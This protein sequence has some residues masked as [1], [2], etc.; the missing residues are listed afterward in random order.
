MTPIQLR[1][2]AKSKEILE[3][4]AKRIYSYMDLVNLYDETSLQL[5]KPSTYRQTYTQN[6]FVNILLE[7]KIIRP[8]TLHSPYQNIPVRYAHG[9]FS[10]YELA[11]SIQKGAYLSHGTAA[12]FHGLTSEESRK[13]YVNKEQS[14]K[15][16]GKGY[17]TQEALN[18]AF[19]R[20]QR[21]SKYIL[22]YGRSRITL[23]NGKNTNRLGVQQSHDQQSVSIDLT[24][25][26]RTLIDITVRPAYAG[27]VSQVL[28]CFVAARNRI[29]MMETIRILKAL[30]YVYPYHQ[31]LGF[32]LERAGFQKQHWSRLKTQGLPYDFYLM[33]GEKELK[34]DPNW[35]IFYP[36]ELAK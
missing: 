14:V 31:A 3:T 25:L 23:L 12:F 13:I 17:L 18:L 30:D 16:P 1:I 9:N 36:S 20:Q 24:G 15:P 34:Y 22:R 2:I 19:S 29:D 26:E 7:H 10:L 5:G 32:Y 11:L 21:Q 8:I 27:G 33:H 4:S 28:H 35:R 6:K